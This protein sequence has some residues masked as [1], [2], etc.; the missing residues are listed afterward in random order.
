VRAGAKLC[1]VAADGRPWTLRRGRWKKREPCPAPRRA[2]RRPARRSLGPEA[3][4]RTRARGRGAGAGGKLRPRGAAGGRA[5]GA[6]GT[7]GR[8]GGRGWGARPRAWG[9]P[10]RTPRPRR[11]KWGVLGLPW[12]FWGALGGCRAGVGGGAR[13]RGEGCAHSSDGSGRGARLTAAKGNGW[14]RGAGR[15]GPGR[16]G[17]GAVRAGRAPPGSGRALAGGTR[18]QVGGGA[19]GIGRDGERRQ[20]MCTGGRARAG[21]KG[22]KGA[23]APL[24][25]RRAGARGRARRAGAPC[26][27][28]AS[29]ACVCLGAACKV[30]GVGG[31]RRRAGPCRGQGCGPG[32]RPRE[33][34][35]APALRRSSCCGGAGG[36]RVA[37]ATASMKRSRARGQLRGGGARACARRHGRRNSVPCWQ[38]GGSVRAGGVPQ[39]GAAAAGPPWWCWR[40]RARGLWAVWVMGGRGAARGRTRAQAGGRAAGRA[41]ARAGGASGRVGEKSGAR[42]GARRRR[43]AA[44]GAPQ[45]AGW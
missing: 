32:R 7:R 12:L 44:G 21:S 1:R 29:A 40:G 43:C 9:R 41:G 25:A 4:A 15:A 11:P 27:A 38:A 17:A 37:G 6:R 22:R 30:R 14:G 34:G 20:G 26:R 33:V 2:A 23:P 42:A 28:R 39:W 45:G 8:V 35:G 31:A 19:Q 36:R 16:R 5:G 3:A 24:P 18:A 13:H 10:A